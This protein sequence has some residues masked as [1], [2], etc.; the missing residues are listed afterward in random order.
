MKA[1]YAIGVSALLLLGVAVQARA[2]GDVP[3][4]VRCP[5]HKTCWG[6]PAR[7]KPVPAELQATGNRICETDKKFSTDTWTYAVGWHPDAK[8]LNGKPIPGGGFNCGDNPNVASGGAATYQ[9][10][11]DPRSIR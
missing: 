6:A 7:F 5:E 2:A 8:D 3:Y 4:M 11:F 1:S 10:R 9:R